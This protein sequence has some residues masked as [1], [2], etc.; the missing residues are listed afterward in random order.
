MIPSAVACFRPFA[1]D[2]SAACGRL[3]LVLLVLLLRRF[4]YSRRLDVVTITFVIDSVQLLFFD[5]LFFL[6]FIIYRVQI[7]IYI[8]F[9]LDL[10]FPNKYFLQFNLFAVINLV[11]SKI[12]I[13]HYLTGL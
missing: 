8:Y 3:L 9:Y 12:T 1:A 10:I 2:S 6:G 4:Q 11:V 7:L 5:I 13:L